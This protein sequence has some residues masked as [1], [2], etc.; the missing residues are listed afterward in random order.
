MNISRRGFLK[1]LQAS[2]IAAALPTT[3]FKGVDLI[4][5]EQHKLL[6]DYNPE[7]EYGNMLR[8]SDKMDLSD[9][10]TVRECVKTLI[11]DAVHHLPQGT[12]F[13]IRSKVP[14]NYGRDR[15]IAWYSNNEFCRKG[16]NFEQFLHLN[17]DDW[18]Y[19]QRLGVYIL[20]RGV[21]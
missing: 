9:S 10:Q 12:P 6:H 20:G 18:H 15:G 1:A 2:I 13:E 5:S 14:E 3:L 17:E 7:F 21:I 19:S 11:A 16:E 8:Y 4:L